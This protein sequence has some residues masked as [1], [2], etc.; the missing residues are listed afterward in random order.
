MCPVG[1]AIGVLLSRRERRD[2]R[3]SHSE[4]S[5]AL[6]TLTSAFAIR[7]LEAFGAVCGVS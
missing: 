3:G 6:L 5:Q 7:G 1:L 4:D 2:F